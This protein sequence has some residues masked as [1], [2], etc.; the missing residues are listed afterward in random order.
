MQ[1]F[2]TLQLTNKRHP[3]LFVGNPPFGLN[4]SLA[5]KF[6]NH[7]AGIAD[8]EGDEIAFIVPATFRRFSVQNRL[9]LNYHCRFTEEIPMGSFIPKTMHA[10]CVFQIWQRRSKPRKKIVVEPSPDFWHCKRSEADIAMKAYGGSG[11]CGTIIEPEEVINPKAYH[12]LKLRTPSIR[13]RLAKLDYYPLSAH[14]VRQDSI[15]MT[16]LY[17]LYN[18]KFG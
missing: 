3:I 1:D 13:H 8:K 14:T 4:S 17:Y 6:F 7:A 12:F 11:D 9:D 16:D 5:V 2:F 10:R 15:G 18:Q